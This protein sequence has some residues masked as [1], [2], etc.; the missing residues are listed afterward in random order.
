MRTPQNIK[1]SIP[2]VPGIEGL[3]SEIYYHALYI[4]VL[5]WRCLILLLSPLDRSQL[6]A[7]DHNNI[8]NSNQ[9][10]SHYC[11]MMVKVAKLNHDRLRQQ[12]TYPR[13]TLW[14]E[15]AIERCINLD[16]CVSQSGIVVKLRTDGGGKHA[17]THIDAIKTKKNNSNRSLTDFNYTQILYTCTHSIHVH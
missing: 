16:G 9:I 1:L 6:Q 4:Q 13:D 7:A 10:F 8:I 5:E 2:R 17:D 12:L 14:S 11:L 15:S 3:K